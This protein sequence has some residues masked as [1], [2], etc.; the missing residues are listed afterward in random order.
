MSVMGVKI[1]QF[2][3]PVCNSF[4]PKIFNGQLCYEADPQKYRKFTD[5]EKLGLSLLISFNEERQYINKTKRRRKKKIQQKL[6]T[7]EIDMEKDKHIF[8]G[9]TSKYFLFRNNNF[10]LLKFFQSLYL[11][12]WEKRTSSMLSKK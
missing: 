6:L 8:I 3:D 4:R 11:L 5:N 2:D 7:L 9:T 12:S 10:K 1:D